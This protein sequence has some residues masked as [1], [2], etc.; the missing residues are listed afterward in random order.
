MAVGRIFMKCPFCSSVHVYE[1]FRIEAILGQ[2]DS[3]IAVW[4]CCHCSKEWDTQLEVIDEDYEEEL[5]EA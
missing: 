1:L 3:D 4:R 2:I 5:E